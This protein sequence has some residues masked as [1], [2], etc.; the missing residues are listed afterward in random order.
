MSRLHPTASLILETMAE[1]AGSILTR[2]EM[3]NQADQ[4]KPIPKP[5]LNAETP[6]DVYPIERLVGSLALRNLPVQNWINKV[7]ANE[8]IHTKSRFVS[9]NINKVVKMKNPELLR[10]LKYLFLLLEWYSCLNV[11]KRGSRKV[12][13]REDVAQAIPWASKDLL[14][15]LTKRFSDG[16]YV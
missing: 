2:E 16:G 13:K 1:S 15:D 11:I 9:A 10:A 8:E 6:A 14:E 4:A 5:N 12:P 3:Q 7:E